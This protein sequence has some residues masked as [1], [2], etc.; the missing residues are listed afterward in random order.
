M[1]EKTLPQN[2]YIEVKSYLDYKKAVLIFAAY[3]YIVRSS[4]NEKKFSERIKT[5][6]V[7]LYTVTSKAISVHTY[8]SDKILINSNLTEFSFTDLME[9]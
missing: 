1:T 8:L 7:Y 5:S 3:G 4:M 6:K 9:Y 2:I